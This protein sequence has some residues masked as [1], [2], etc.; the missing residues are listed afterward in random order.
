MSKQLH[1][2]KKN[3]PSAHSTMAP[4]AAS[5]IRTPPRSMHFRYSLL[6]QV[7]E[8]NEV[9]ISALVSEQGKLQKRLQSSKADNAVLVKEK[10]ENHEECSKWKSK[11][12][13]LEVRVVL[14]LT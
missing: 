3:S 5:N 2:Y 6:T 11:A 4:G 9:R 13:R 8:G 12:Q 10:E 1:F 7:N 14:L